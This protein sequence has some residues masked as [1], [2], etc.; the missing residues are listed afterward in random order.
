[1]CSDLKCE[2][3]DVCDKF[4]SSKQ[5]SF[6]RKTFCDGV[7]LDLVV[8]CDASKEAYGTAIYAVQNEKSNLIFSKQKLAPNSSKT[9]P[10]LELLA[11]YLGFCN[12]QTLVEDINFGGTVDN[13]IFVTD[14]QVALSWLIKGKALKRNMFVN[15]RLQDIN[16]MKTTFCNNGMNVVF[17]FVPSAAN[18]SQE[19]LISTS[20]LRIGIVGYLDQNG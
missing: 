13:V 9:L 18:M 19:L 16:G 8:F 6:P 20:L 15:N 17:K 1:M 5:L 2:W 14:S 7:I 12:V 10:T 4:N 3:E 11:V